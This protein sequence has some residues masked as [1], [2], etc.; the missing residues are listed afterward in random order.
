MSGKSV[1]LVLREGPYLGP[2]IDRERYR[3]R[4]RR[5]KSPAPGGIRTHDLSVMRRV[6][7]HCAITSASFKVVGIKTVNLSVGRWKTRD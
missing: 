1:V 5:E 3:E 7:Y 2:L 4:K 6:L